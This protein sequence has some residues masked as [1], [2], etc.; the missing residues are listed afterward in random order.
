[1]QVARLGNPLV[2]EVLIPLRAKDRYNATEPE[3][4]AKNIQDF[5]VNP[6]TSQPGGAALIPFLNSLTGC[7]PT[8]GRA[9]LDLI[10]LRGIDG[11]TASALAG[12][13][14]SLAPFAT[15]GGNQNTEEDDGP[16]VGDMLRLNINVPPTASGARNPLGFFG[17]DPAGFPN[18]RRVGDDV[19]DIDARAAAGG[20]LHAL[21][22]INCPVSVGLSDNVQSNDVPYLDTFPY[23]GLPHQGF[24]H[25]HDH[26]VSTV[27]VLS[28]GMG[29]LGLLL[30]AAVAGP[31]IIGA[32]RRRVTG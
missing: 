3:D 9:D 11:G 28:L 26:G 15:A 19:L 12:A 24:S 2:N 20:V 17:G 30:A 27:T 5:I 21:G 16:E 8:T 25:E 18:G 32:I 14:P 29:L 31:R 4:D 22:A 23:L 6:G 7:T 1:V 10:L 13:I